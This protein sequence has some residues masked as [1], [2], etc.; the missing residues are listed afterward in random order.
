MPPFTINPVYMPHMRSPI[1]P[2]SDVTLVSYSRG[3]G[4]C[5]KAA[6]QL[7]AEGMTIEPPS[8]ELS[9]QL[10]EIGAEMSAQWLERAGDVGQ[11]VLDR[12][13]DMRN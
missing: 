10:A 9:A 6:E 2:G 1:C 3:V 8:D 7:A 11:E 4:T 13:E 12:Y 5:L